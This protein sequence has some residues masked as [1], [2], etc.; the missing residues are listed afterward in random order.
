MRY[1]KPE[2]IHM[3]LISL[4][5]ATVAV[6]TFAA[7]FVRP[8]D[9]RF[10]TIL[11]VAAVVAGLV[12]SMTIVTSRRL[13]K[14]R[15]Q[16][17][18][19]IIYAKEDLDVARQLAAELKERG[20]K[21]WLDVDEITP[22]EVWTRA[23][24]RALERSTVAIVLVSKHLPKTGFVHEELSL[25]LGALPAPNKDMSPVI[26]VRLDDSEVPEGLSHVAWVD[27][28]ESGGKERLL[29]GLAKLASGGPERSTS[30]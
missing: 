19:F 18:V 23:V 25:A 30:G 8:I 21:P 3:L 28:Y 9:E 17:R 6:A 29:S 5:M 7:A 20:L 1:M 12:A 10:T 24:T 11:A 16:G 27:L 13:E 2:R 26:P 15:E 22:G 4:V 14:E